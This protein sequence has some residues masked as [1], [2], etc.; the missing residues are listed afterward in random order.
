M[1]SAPHTPAR[2]VPVP[3][4]GFA[5]MPAV[6][7]VLAGFQRDQLASFVEVAISLL[8]I[9]DPDPDLEENGDDELVGDEEDAAWTEHH[10]RGRHKLAMGAPTFP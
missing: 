2:G 7:R 3:A 6:A 10:A 8:D 5:P 1:A 9:A 4:I